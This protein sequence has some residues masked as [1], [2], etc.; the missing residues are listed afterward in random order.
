MMTSGHWLDE[1][2]LAQGSLVNFLFKFCLNSN[3]WQ[4]ALLPL[5][6]VMVGSDGLIAGA[7]G[8]RFTLCIIHFRQL[9]LN[10]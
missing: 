4:E 10:E 2:E 9:E 3:G 5:E 6:F 1:W 7:K 8:E